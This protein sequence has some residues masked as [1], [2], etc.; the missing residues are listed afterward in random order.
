MG[1]KKSGGLGCVMQFGLNS[2]NF[3][4]HCLMN[5]RSENQHA[6]A[7]WIRIFK[8]VTERCHCYP[9]LFKQRDRFLRQCYHPLWFQ[10][11]P[12]NVAKPVTKAAVFI[13]VG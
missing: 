9:N 12:V 11:V 6:A 8:P 10:F 4:H 7:L 13:C 5:G 1:I 3:E 2:S